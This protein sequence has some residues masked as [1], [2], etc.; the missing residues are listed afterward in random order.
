MEAQ[1]PGAAGLQDEMGAIM[2][3]SRDGLHRRERGILAFSYRD[4]RDVWREKYTGT[5]DRAEARKFRKA[6]LD[7]LWKAT[8]PTDM[9]GWRME[10]AEKWWINFRALR[11]ADTTFYS[12]KYRLKRFR[13]FLG[14]KQLCEITN[15]DLDRYVTKRLEEGAVAWSIN[16]EIQL[17]SLILKRAKLWLRLRDD[18]EPLPTRVSDIGHVV[19]REELRNLVKIA[20]K[21][22]TWRAVFYAFVLAAN[23]GLRGG[24]IK[25]LQI[26]AVDVERGRLV[27]RRDSAKSDASARHIELNRDAAEAARQLLSRARSL[28]SLKPE[29]F[30]MPKF[31]SRIKFGPEA[32]TRGYDPTQHQKYWR[33]AWASLTKKAGL[34]GIRFHD[35]RHTFI[36]HMIERGV[37][38][39]LVQAFV[40]H[41]NAR[42]VRHYTHITS[43]AA[44]KAVELLDSE[45]ILDRN[46][47]Q[48]DVQ[49][50][51]Y[52]GQ[53][54][55]TPL[56]T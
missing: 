28:G 6:F 10:D 42:M 39:G 23:T 33:T 49:S 13:D 7:G 45:P 56:A 50:K 40:G 9:A 2:A 21:K 15:G 41:I 47:S 55:A 14:N 54:T 38:V 1:P 43:G 12:E 48:T 44:R 35:L 24:E 32:G 8:L 34:K 36:T 31:L 11:I 16:K 46:A 52:F 26:G 3:R 19:S 4:E 27:V 53:E 22:E 51:E 17:W 30:L 18:Y 20:Q 37:P 25:K 29:H 5:R